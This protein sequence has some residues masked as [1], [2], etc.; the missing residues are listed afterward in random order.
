M[1]A[2]IFKEF[3]RFSK[4][5]SVPRQSALT[6]PFY[7]GEMK[8]PEGGA[9]MQ[10]EKNLFYLDDELLNKYKNW[11]EKNQFSRTLDG[12]SESEIYLPGSSV[13]FWLNDEPSEYSVHWH[14]A[15]EMIIPLENIY[16]V[17]T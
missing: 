17:I 6:N 11:Q 15:I 10:E 4:L 8:E 7:S 13:R 2:I 9:S 5:Q 12:D 1:Q 14:P 16:T 3:S